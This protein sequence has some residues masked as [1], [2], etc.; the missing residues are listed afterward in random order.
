MMKSTLSK[1]VVVSL[2]FFTLLMGYGAKV[3]QVI[4]LAAPNKLNEK[5]TSQVKKSP[6]PEATMAP[7][8]TPAPVFGQVVYEGIALDY[9]KNWKPFDASLDGNSQVL[10]VDIPNFYGTIVGGLGDKKYLSQGDFKYYRVGMVLL[11]KGIPPGS[12]LKDLFVVTYSSQYLSNRFSGV[13]DVKLNGIPALRRTYNV[14]T[15]GAWYSVSDFWFENQ[16]V[17]YIISC[18]AE[19]TDTDNLADPG[20][21]TILNSV[22]VD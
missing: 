2:L 21:L 3:Q 12:S 11:K 16:G 13:S 4:S 15:Q 8:S 20:F 22:R 18:R 9:A 5:A 17:A 14:F 7:T 6:A 19:Y 1:I 10:T